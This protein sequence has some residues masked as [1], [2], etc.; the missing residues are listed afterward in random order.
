[1]KQLQMGRRML[2]VLEDLDENSPSIVKDIIL[3]V[4]GLE[5]L[6]GRKRTKS[7][8]SAF[9]YSLTRLLEHGLVEWVAPY[10]ITE[11]GERYIRSCARTLHMKTI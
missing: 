5:E 2:Q 6:P 1:M 4:E 8:Y 9:N 10:R 3:R 7:I 11:K